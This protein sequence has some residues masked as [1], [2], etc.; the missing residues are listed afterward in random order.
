MSH[1][2]SL[3]PILAPMSPSLAR[4]PRGD[5]LPQPPAGNLAT[6]PLV[7]NPSMRLDPSLGLVVLEFR[8]AQGQLD[9]SLPTQRELDAYHQAGRVTEP[10]AAPTKPP[11]V[12]K[13]DATAPAPDQ[14]P[15]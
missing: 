15:A 6:A 9:H 12:A 11:M 14:P 5:S 13:P 3:S 1:A 10:H 8:N 7:S 2:Q 4:A